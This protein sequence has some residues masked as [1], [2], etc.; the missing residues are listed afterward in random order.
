MAGPALDYLFFVA[1]E[2]V[3]R[4]ALVRF[5]PGC[6]QP[7]C[8]RVEREMKISLNPTELAGPHGIAV[9]PDGRHYYV[10]T[11][12]G[13]PS[14]SLW[15]FTTVG[16]SL[17]GR[18]QLGAFPATVDL[19]PNGA[20]AWV[21]NFNLHGDMVPSTVSVVYV[22]E[23][24]EVARMSTCVMP[25]GSRLTAEG[26]KHYSVCMMDDHLIEIDAQAMKVARHFMLKRGSEHGMAGPPGQHAGGGMSGGG[27]HE[28]REPAAADASCSPT[29]AQP[30]ADG[31]RIFV[32]CSKSSD[33]VEIEGATWT[34]RRRIPMG[35]GVYNLALTSDGGLLI[36]TNKRGQSVSIVDVVTG[37]ELA[38][39]ATKRPV[40]SGVALSADDRYAFVTVEGVGSEP[41]TVEI[42]DLGALR[43]VATVDVGQMAGGIA[44]WKKKQGMAR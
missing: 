8:A 19:S 23:M 15:K 11:A 16:D 13:F 33:V 27:G 2:A 30:T 34:M 20:Y 24:V 4:I 5:T 1:A 14:G 41:G 42:I 35:E 22:D 12:H 32:A 40:P 21:V 18:V 29:W 17:R 25:H 26:S 36:G 3:D 44:I 38:R 28:M 37:K 31:S 39:L 7:P 6:A 9:S 10:T 43:T